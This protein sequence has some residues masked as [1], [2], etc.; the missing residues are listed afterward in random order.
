MTFWLILILINYFIKLCIQFKSEKIFKIYNLEQCTVRYYIIYSACIACNIMYLSFHFISYIS[1]CGQNA[2]DILL[3][4]FIK[5]KYFKI[6]FA[7]IYKISW[8]IT[9]N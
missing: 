6:N 3:N 9:Y 1:N 2:F 7:L 8:Y 4:V 5:K